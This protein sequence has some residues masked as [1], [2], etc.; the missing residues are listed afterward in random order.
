MDSCKIIDQIG[1]IFDI[2]SHMDQELL[3]IVGEVV[4]KMNR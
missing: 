1:T 3:D 2:S 4:L